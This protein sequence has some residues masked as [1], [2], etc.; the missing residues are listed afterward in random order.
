[1]TPLLNIAILAARDAGQRILELSH[2]TNFENKVDGTPV[3]IADTEANEILLGHLAKTEYPILSEESGVIDLPYPEHIWIIDPLDGTQEFIKKTKDY[4]VMIGLLQNGRPILG[5]IY[6]PAYDTLYYAQ[7]GC[8]AFVM[9]NEQT[10]R[11]SVTN[12]TSALR[13]INRP[14]AVVENVIQKL[15][16]TLTTPCG[17]IGIKSGLLGEQIGDFFFSWGTLGE[18]D[19]CASEIITEEAGGRVTDCYGE[20]LCY[21]SQSHKTHRGIVFSNRAC[22]SQVLEAVASTTP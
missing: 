9:R 6:A 21:G 10:S 8:G 22:H 15:S 7:K 11:L 14:S 18:W 20:P 13:A 12:H 2:I 16:A 19:I 1:M 5:V 3:T 17:S 4:S